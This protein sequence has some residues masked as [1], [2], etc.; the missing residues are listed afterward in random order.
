[1]RAIARAA[2]SIALRPLSG[3]IPAWA[4]RPTKVAWIFR[5]DGAAVTIEPMSPVW[6]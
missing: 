3:V 2:A 6:S 5:S 1:M 4:A